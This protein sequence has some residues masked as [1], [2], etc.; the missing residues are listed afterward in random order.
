MSMEITV[1]Q[2]DKVLDD[3][4]SAY[5]LGKI[6]NRNIVFIGNEGIGR[7]SRIKKWLEA[8]SDEVAPYYPTPAVLL[9]EKN[10]IYVNDL[11]NG[12]PQYLFDSVSMERL[13][14]DGMICVCKNLNHYTSEYIQPFEELFS[15]R[16]YSVPGT[17]DKQDIHKL[18]LIIAT[19]YPDDFGY[20]VEDIS[21]IKKC[22]DVY[23]VTPSVDEFKEYFDN[24]VSTDIDNEN[25][26]ENFKKILSSPYFQFILEK[27]EKFLP[28]NFMM[29]F[30]YCD[31]GN[32]EEVLS[33]LTPNKNTLG[34]AKEKTFEMFKRIFSNL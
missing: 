21:N 24:E 22:S 25:K 2:I 28:C 30:M 4:L 7:S 15:D 20:N 16:T 14:A 31:T 23:M 18:F 3:A 13:S 19:A 12:K 1:N 32:A 34:A 33:M 17:D 9:K 11:K 27:D 6:Q 8:H 5:K 10:G 26:I 29:L